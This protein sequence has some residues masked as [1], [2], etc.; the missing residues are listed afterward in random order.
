MVVVVVKVGEV[1]SIITGVV[2]I[3]I[4]ISALVSCM[5]AIVKIWTV[6]T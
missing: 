2:T 1:A 4:S 5:M 3:T 6:A